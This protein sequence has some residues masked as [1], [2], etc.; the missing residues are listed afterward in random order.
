[1]ELGLNENQSY[2]SPMSFRASST[3]E[4]S[5]VTIPQRIH[6]P[7]DGSRAVA[8][9]S[10]FANSDSTL[11]MLSPLARNPS[12]VSSLGSFPSTSTMRSS[13]P[14]PFE[15]ACVP[16]LPPLPTRFQKQQ[17]GEV[18]QAQGQ[19]Q[20][21]SSS[22][23]SPSQLPP[24]DFWHH[25][26]GIEISDCLDV[27][28]KQQVRKAYSD[29]KSPEPEQ[30]P[31]TV[32]VRQPSMRRY[33]TVPPQYQGMKIPKVSSVEGTDNPS[34]RPSLARS[35]VSYEDLRKGQ[36]IYGRTS[37]ELG[38]DLLGELQQNEQVNRWKGDEQLMRR[39]QS[40]TLVKQRQP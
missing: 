23:K 17:P 20:S 37:F 10:S 18:E 2:L 22:L 29:E 27:S 26:A 36:S 16:K 33:S 5:P 21:P 38:L 14:S 30:Q 40:R 8:K 1:M 6:S 24:Q 35:G 13:P 39:K 7:F 11:A 19:R 12:V 25:T 34:A 31:S 3:K 4:K 28:P 32:R 9:Q 15:Q